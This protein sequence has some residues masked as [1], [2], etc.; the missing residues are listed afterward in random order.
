MGLA[1]TAFL[2]CRMDPAIPALVVQLSSSDDGQQFVAAVALASYSL[3]GDS[4]A[5]TA[6]GAIPPLV[7]L[8]DGTEATQSAAA[9]ALANLCYPS[10]IEA[11]AAAGAIP[12]LVRLLGAPFEVTQQAAIRALGS[13]CFRSPSNQEAAAAA[14]A[15]PVLVHLLGATCEET[16]EAAVWA[17][18]M[19]SRHLR[20][21]TASISAHGI[22]ALNC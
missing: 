7:R 3:C 11:I 21:R 14:G 17:L 22:P 5:I 12:P 19:L 16:Q 2:L 18:F 6:A 8:L 1:P 20:I 13:L 15:I 9:W 10:N 4:L